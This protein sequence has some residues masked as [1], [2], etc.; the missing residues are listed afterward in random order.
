MV[1]AFTGARLFSRSHPHERVEDGLAWRVRGDMV[2]GLVRLAA[3][4]FVFSEDE[5]SFPVDAI[6]VVRWAGLKQMKVDR[7]EFVVRWR[8]HVKAI[9]K[10]LLELPKADGGGEVAA[11]KFILASHDLSL[12][13]LHRFDEVDIL[14][15][16]D[17]A[18][19]GPFVVLHYLDADE[20]TP[21]LLFLA[22]SC[23]DAPA[24]PP[25][26]GA[27]AHEGAVVLS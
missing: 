14:V 2:E 22:H 3:A 24:P 21:H 12:K 11:D 17:E 23:V 5:D 18:K 13:V 26:H 27:V 9:E 4:N 19:A 7:S 1:C 6:D 10:R 20:A 8:N 15:G 16:A 25:P